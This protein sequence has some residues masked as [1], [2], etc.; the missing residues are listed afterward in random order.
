LLPSEATATPSGSSEI[1]GMSILVVTMSVCA[2]IT[3]TVPSPE[4]AT[5]T[6]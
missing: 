2:E 6:S 5:S 1:I 4:F 3:D